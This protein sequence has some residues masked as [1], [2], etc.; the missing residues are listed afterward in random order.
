MFDAVCGNL[1]IPYA[2]YGAPFHLLFNL[3]GLVKCF[4]GEFCQVIE[5]RLF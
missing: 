5:G 1:H 4:K 2:E 3:F